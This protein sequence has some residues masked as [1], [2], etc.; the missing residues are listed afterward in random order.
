MPAQGDQDGGG[1]AAAGQ[2]MAGMP[3]R[4]A[5]IPAHWLLGLGTEQPGKEVTGLQD[6]ERQSPL[7][8]REPRRGSLF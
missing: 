2:E 7:R 4:D 5:S 8:A 3:G 1:W 6:N